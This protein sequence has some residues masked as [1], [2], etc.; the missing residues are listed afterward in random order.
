MLYM[1]YSIVPYMYIHT[2]VCVCMYV[3]IYIYIY[4]IA[5]A[6][7]RV[8]CIL[9]SGLGMARLFYMSYMYTCTHVH[10]RACAPIHVQAAYTRVY[11]LHV[12]TCVY[13]YIYIHTYVC[14]HRERERG[15]EI[16]TRIDART[17]T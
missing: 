1:I 17:Q 16:H 12:Y 7:M 10:M 2:Y 15:R 11:M 9:W 8:D 5:R 4:I 13:I 6:C 14:T 3:Y